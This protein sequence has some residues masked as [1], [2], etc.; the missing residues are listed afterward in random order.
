MVNVLSVIRDRRYYELEDKFKDRLHKARRAFNLLGD[1]RI[2]DMI[3]VPLRIIA[4]IHRTISIDGDYY[5]CKSED[6]I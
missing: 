2:G 3:S 1:A 4:S 5:G 6:K